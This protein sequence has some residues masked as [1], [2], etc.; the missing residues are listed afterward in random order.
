MAIVD[1]SPLEYDPFSLYDDPYP[2]YQRLRDEAP[3]YR[4]PRRGFW[5]L[6]RFDDVSEASKDWETFSNAKGILLGLDHSFYGSGDFLD[7]DPPVHDELRQVLRFAFVPRAI[8]ALEPFVRNASERLLDRCVELGEADAARELAWLLPLEVISNMLGVPEGDTGQLQGWCSA[9]L[10]R[11]PGRD[12]MSDRA[13]TATRAMRGYFAALAERKRH[14]PEP[15]LISA[16]TAAR[17]PDGRALSDGELQGMC[18]L[19]ITAG[20]ETTASLISTAMLVLAEHPEQRALLVSRPEL[21]PQAVEE[22]L[23]YDSPIQQLGRV[24]TRDVE[25]YDQTIPHGSWVA[26]VYASANRDGRRFPEPARFDILRE[27]KRNLAFGDGIHF[28]L[29]A[30]LARLEARTAIE[31]L[32]RRCPQYEVLGTP[33]RTPY[34]T[35]RGLSELRVAFDP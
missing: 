23:R 33:R 4:N 26:L 19:V 34:L 1:T 2:I 11:E 13:E 12:G 9:I 22:I 31:H 25:L 32:L 16:M 5:A 15:D 7:S 27:R 3:V 24:T 35:S 10:S 21:I 29:G 6:S 28:C 20:M 14:A 8:S 30:P 17:L 18:L